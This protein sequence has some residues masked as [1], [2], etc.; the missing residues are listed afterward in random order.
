MAFTVSADANFININAGTGTVDDLY[1]ALYTYAGDAETYMTKAGSVYTT[2]GNREINVYDAVVLTIDTGETITWDLTVNKTSSALCLD[3]SNGGELVIEAGGVFQG[4]TNTS[5][6]ATA[7]IYGSITV[8]GTPDNRAIFEHWD[9]IYLYPLSSISN[10]NKIDIEY[11]EVRDYFDTGSA[12]FT[13]GYYMSQVSHSIRDVYFHGTMNYAFIVYC[14]TTNIEL[15]RIDADGTR[16]CLNLGGI[17]HFKNSTFR[18]VETYPLAGTYLN[19]CERYSMYSDDQARWNDEVPVRYKCSYYPRCTFYN[20]TFDNNYTT[21]TTR[22]AAYM[23]AGGYLFYKCKF[24]NGVVGVDTVNHNTTVY[25]YDPEFDNITTETAI[26]AGAT[27][28]YCYALALTVL[29]QNGNFLE[30]A[31]VY[32]SQSE[33]KENLWFRT[34]DG[35]GGTDPSIPTNGNIFDRYGYTPIVTYKEE[36]S[37]E[38]FVQWSDDVDAGRYHLIA[39]VKEGYQLWQR[40]VAFTSDQDIVAVLHPSPGATPI[41]Q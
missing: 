23:Y 34:T 22:G 37:D 35:T 20:C 26:W 6:A 33:G 1:N 29:D 25:L 2:Q 14:D 41:E 32:I 4:D 8:N 38:S 27:I 13:L 16:R 30:D 39:I 40:K 28:K 11:A 21:S 5:N 24:R 19:A 3:V 12:G 9:Y 36:L 15:D 18:N 7:R 17:A 31:N 10:E